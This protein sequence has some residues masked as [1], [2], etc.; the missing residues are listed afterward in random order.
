MHISFYMIH[1]RLIKSFPE[2]PGSR[3]C[4][5]DGRREREEVEGHYGASQ[6]LSG[7][8]G[9]KPEAPDNI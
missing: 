7:A 2:I 8:Q 4:R 1:N 6:T 5:G 9:R 3:G